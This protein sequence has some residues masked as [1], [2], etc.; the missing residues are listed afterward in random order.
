[1]SL[2]KLQVPDLCDT[3]LSENLERERTFAA[4]WITPFGNSFLCYVNYVN[5][6]TPNPQLVGDYVGSRFDIYCVTIIIINYSGN[7]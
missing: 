3:H 1:M 6:H 4:I 2:T 7:E 5:R